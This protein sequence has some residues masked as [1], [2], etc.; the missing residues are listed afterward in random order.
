M[1]EWLT[2]LWVLYGLGWVMPAV[3]AVLAY[4]RGKALLVQREWHVRRTDEMTEQW[5]VALRDRKD[6]PG[7]TREEQNEA[8][9]DFNRE[10]HARFYA[11]GLTP[12]HYGNLDPIG[13]ATTVRVLRLIFQ[14][15]GL[16]LALVLSGPLLST[17]ASIVALYPPN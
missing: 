2:T 1:G 8:N 10:W 12:P 6:T 9:E 16:N 3:G 4:R 5:N 7:L 15:N 13:N 14:G 11:E 17:I